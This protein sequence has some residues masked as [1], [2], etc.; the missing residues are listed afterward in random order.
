MGIWN[1][2]VPWRERYKLFFCDNTFC[3]I[4]MADC[5]PCVWYSRYST[6]LYETWTETVG[7]RSQYNL[8]LPLI[9]R[10]PTTQL[11]SVNFNP[12]VFTSGP[13]ARKTDPRQAVRCVAACHPFAFNT[14]GQDLSDLLVWW[15]IIYLPG[16]VIHLPAAAWESMNK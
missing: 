13:H 16:S 14:C 2:A 8:S 10:D 15:Y 11:I 5:V 4:V 7:E 12:Q 9:S 1:N 6:S 3:L